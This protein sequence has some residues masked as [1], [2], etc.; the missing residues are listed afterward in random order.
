MNIN[1]RRTLIALAVVSMFGVAQAYAHDDGG[2]SVKISKKVSLKSDISISGDPRV[3]GEIDVNAAAVALSNG[4]QS[5]FWNS[6]SNSGEVV[7]SASISGNVGNGVSGNIGVN[8]ASGDL[9]AQGNQAAI[10]AAGSSTSDAGFTFNCDHNGG[11]GGDPGSSAGSMA[12]AETFATQSS[13]FSRTY[14]HGTTNSASASG[15]AFENASGNVGVN[16]AAGDGNEQLNQLSAATAQNVDYAVAT[17]TLDQEWSGNRVD[18]DP[19]SL[20]WCS[21]PV[22]TSNNA[23]LSG[24]VL[25]NASGN[26]GLNQA[27]GT[28]NMQSNSLAMGVSNP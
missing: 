17:S 27:A 2:S 24:H 15:H 1:L 26:I 8:Q 20:G 14:N 6:V 10:A 19:G 16:Q 9:N 12:D 22:N 7:N 25:A 3:N 5:S 4:T 11:C 18:N 23:S 13:A 28:G 21:Y